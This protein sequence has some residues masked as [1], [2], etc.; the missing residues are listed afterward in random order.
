M[1]KRT[2]Y[3]RVMIVAIN[4]EMRMRWKNIFPCNYC[5]HKS[6]NEN[7]LK[8]HV[9]EH[10]IFPCNDC[11]HKSRNEHE[12]KKLVEEHH[13]FLCDDC[14]HKSRND[15]EKIK[16][17]TARE[18]PVLVKM[19]TAWGLRAQSPP[20]T[21][22]TPPL[23]APWLRQLEGAYHDSGLYPS[24]LPGRSSSPGRS[25]P[26]CNL[27]SGGHWPPPPGVQKIYIHFF[28]ILYK[29]FLV[30]QFCSNIKSL[31]QTKCKILSNNKDILSDILRY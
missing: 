3:S 20:V 13:P 18:F 24:L 23:A 30:K 16:Q 14:G 5:G 6:R 26:Q 4:H 8:E 9:E 15:N 28:G 19:Q 27:F 2:I 1:L 31:H 17:V 29:S 7:G 25:S 22:A 12:L 10:H 11:G 21:Q